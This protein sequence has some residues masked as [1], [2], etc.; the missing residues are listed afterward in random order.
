MCVT[1]HAL[2]VTFC[3]E[4]LNG[5]DW[6][7]LL[8]YPPPGLYSVQCVGDSEW[9]VTNDAVASLRRAIDE[10]ERAEAAGWEARSVLQVV[11]P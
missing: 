8:A 7:D 5:I 2:R 4:D 11:E 10:G 6:D 9:P 1:C 3:D